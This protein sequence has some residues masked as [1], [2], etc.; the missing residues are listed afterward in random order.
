MHSEQKSIFQSEFLL[1]TCM[2][3]VEQGMRLTSVFINILYS[4][5]ILIYT[6]YIYIHIYCI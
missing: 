4:L 3:T 6:V 2:L 5:Y 1:D